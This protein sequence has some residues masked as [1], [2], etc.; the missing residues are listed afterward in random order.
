MSDEIL[1]LNDEAT[2]TEF[3]GEKPLRYYQ[4][5]AR[6]QT[7]L[8]L[9]NGSKRILIKLPTGTGKTVTIACSMAFPRIRAAL[10]VTEERNLR[11]LFVAHNR[12]LLTQAERTFAAENGVDLLVQSMFSEIPAEVIK[13][14]WD[15]TVIDEAHHEACA[16]FQYHLEKLGDR[17]IIGLTATDQRS[18]GSLIK[19]EEIIEPLTRDEAVARGFLAETNIHSFV[20]VPSKDKIKIIS[21]I[22]T[23]FIHQMGKT[24]LFVKTK[25]EA[26]AIAKHITDLGYSA[27][28]LTDQSSKEI[29]QILDDFSDGKIQF[30]VNVNRLGEGI[31][32]RGC[33]TVFIGRTLGSYSL[34]NQ[35]VGRANRGDVDETN[36]WEL[37]NPLSARNLDTTTIVG[38]PK[39]HRLVSHERGNWVERLFDYVSHRTNKQIGLAAGGRVH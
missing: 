24:I 30:V 9:E 14:G 7:A 5:A 25:K 4:V 39:S 16:S 17:P 20:D 26:T 13:Q 1:D 36:V 11:V 37:V 23:N 29:N 15:V 28:G 12:R 31:D 10:G 22:M 34:L 38:V 35:I 18:D 3:F 33:D 27:V 2:V 8:A 32:V 19:F 21:D 6:N